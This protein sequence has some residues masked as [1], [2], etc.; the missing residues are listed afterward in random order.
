VVLT[1]IDRPNMF[2]SARTLCAHQSEHILSDRGYIDLLTGSLTSAEAGAM[3]WSQIVEKDTE[4][5]RFWENEAA[6]IKAALASGA[7]SHA[8]IVTG[9]GL[10]ERQAEYEKWTTRAVESLVASAY[11]RL[12][13]SISVF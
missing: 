1:N 5:L 9:R 6:D 10:P 12:R 13:I 3:V 2:S 7:I 4:Q 11:A 8:R